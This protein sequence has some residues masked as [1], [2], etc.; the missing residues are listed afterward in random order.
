MI[1]DLPPYGDSLRQLKGIL[2]GTDYISLFRRDAPAGEL[3]MAFGSSQC[4]NLVD[5][6]LREHLKQQLVGI[7]KCFGDGQT[8]RQ[9]KDSQDKIEKTMLEERPV[10]LLEWAI[11]IC[12]GHQPPGETVAEFAELV[13]NLVNVSPSIGPL[14]RP[15]I[16]ILLEELPTSEA[17]HFWAVMIRLR[18]EK[19]GKAA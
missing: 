2:R 4:M 19:H 11:N 16:Q 15:I 3:A 17:K 1:G 12:L 5:E 18:T 6:K 8:R 13:T 7:A 9:D 14:F 10:L